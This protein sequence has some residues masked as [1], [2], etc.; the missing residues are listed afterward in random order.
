MD[1]LDTYLT[2]LDEMV[3]DENKIVTYKCLSQQLAIPIS[4]SKELLKIYAKNSENK[5]LST[6]FCVTGCTKNGIRV[7]IV[8]NSDLDKAKSKMLKVTGCHVYSVQQSQVSNPSDLYSADYDMTKGIMYKCASFGPVRYNGSTPLSD[9]EIGEARNQLTSKAAESENTL[10][11]Q[12]I[13]AKPKKASTKTNISNMFANSSTKD[14]SNRV[15]TEN[16][17]ETAVT[18]PEPHKSNTQDQAKG[19]ETKCKK[20]EPAMQMFL[21]KEKGDPFAKSKAPAS[22]VKKEM[23]S[24]PSNKSSVT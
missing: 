2:A 11:H 15:K 17:V 16:T 22:K 4:Q 10:K 21:T 23:L 12:P 7:A 14:V 9:E 20:P 6:V 19:K 24:P 5:M 13:Q 3:E 18:K 1:N 8:K